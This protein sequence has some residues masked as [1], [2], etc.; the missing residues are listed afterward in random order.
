MRLHELRHLYA[1]FLVNSGWMLYEVQHILG[2]S[3]A[4]VTERYALLSTKSLMDAGNSASA[5]IQVPKVVPVE[6][7]NADATVAAPSDIV[8]VWIVT[9]DQ[10]GQVPVVGVG[11]GAASMSAWLGEGGS[12]AET[13]LRPNRARSTN[14]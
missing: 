1:S 2:H 8:Q 6:E 5:F 3:S 11:M 10:A 4:A 13:G 9:L 7:V 12:W 14:S